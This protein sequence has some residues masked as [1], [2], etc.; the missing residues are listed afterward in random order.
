LIGRYGKSAAK[1]DSPKTHSPLHRNFE[2]GNDFG[3]D[4]RGIF[5]YNYNEEICAL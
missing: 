5:M 4:E 3:I 1:S 2:G